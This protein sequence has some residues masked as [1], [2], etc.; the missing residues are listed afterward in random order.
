MQ[1]GDCMNQQEALLVEVFLH[2]ARIKGLC[3][4]VSR[5]TRLSE[6]L[7]TQSGVLHLESAVVTMSVGAPMHAPSLTIEKKAIIAAIP[8][9]TK[10]QNHQRELATSM[11]GRAQTTPT[12]IVAFSPPFA[13]SGTAHLAGSYGSGP[14]DLRADPSVFAHFF[15]ITEAQM[16]LPDGSTLEAPVILVNRDAVSAM[17]RAAEPSTLRLVA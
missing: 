14:R 13:V 5:R 9:E 15:S 1:M 7:N 8:W 6:V 3:D 11:T 10:V 12:D 17:A 2:G 16:T 4:S